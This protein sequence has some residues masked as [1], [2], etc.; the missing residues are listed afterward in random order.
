METS[1]K[2]KTIAIHIEVQNTHRISQEVN[3]IRQKCGQLIEHNMRKDFLVKSYTKF[4]AETI[5]THLST[6]W[7][8]SISMDK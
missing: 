7:K 3:R 2:K 1:W 4:G 5:P 6:K 8:L